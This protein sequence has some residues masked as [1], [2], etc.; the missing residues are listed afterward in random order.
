MNQKLTEKE[1]I[2]PDCDHIGHAAVRLRGS[3]AVERFM[4]YAL[5]FPGPIYSFWRRSAKQIECP[6]CRGQNLVPLDSKL[7]TVML[8][9]RLRE[10][11]T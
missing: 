11:K 6:G 2:C 7:G 3:A 4:W 5:L 1:F 9:N 10:K 8:E